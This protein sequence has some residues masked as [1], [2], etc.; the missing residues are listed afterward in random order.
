MI[1]DSI[2]NESIRKRLKKRKMSKKFDHFS[3]KETWATPKHVEYALAHLL[4]R[5]II[6]RIMY[7]IYTLKSNFKS[8][9]PNIVQE[10]TWALL[11][12]LREKKARITTLGYTL[13]FT[14]R[15]WTYSYPGTQRFGSSLYSLETFLQICNRRH[16]MYKNVQT[17]IVCNCKTTTK[18]L[19]TTQIS[20]K[21]IM[22][23]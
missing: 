20:I 10:K 23:R 2:R 16:V 18:P 19:K 1:H 3:G 14:Q 12:W 13:V 21:S 17:N 6:I 5:K 11:R 4:I 8:T 15:N 22:N 7:F 9:N